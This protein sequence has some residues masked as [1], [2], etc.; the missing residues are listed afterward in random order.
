MFFLKPL[1][2]YLTN[3]RQNLEDRYLAETA[4]DAEKS[5]TFY[6][7]SV[8]SVASAISREQ[9]E[10]ARDAFGNKIFFGYSNIPFDD[11]TVSIRGS[12]P[13]ASSS[14][15]PKALKIASTI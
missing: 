13:V 1:F 11:I 3:E 2:L 7:S 6:I 5:K 8:L 10:R 14:A 9:S 4:E 15:R 12:R